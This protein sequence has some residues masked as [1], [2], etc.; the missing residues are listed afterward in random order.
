MKIYFKGSK[1]S[2]KDFPGNPVVKT[3][4]FYSRGTGLIPGW[5][6]KILHAAHGKKKTHQ[7][8]KTMCTKG[9]RKVK[10]QPTEWRKY[11]NI[12]YVVRYPEYLKNS[13]NSVIA[14]TKVTRQTPTNSFEKAR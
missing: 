9:H 11:L 1:I 2:Q 12:I 8:K 5:G 10:R 14:T 7:K 13:H 4:D 3:S 6:T